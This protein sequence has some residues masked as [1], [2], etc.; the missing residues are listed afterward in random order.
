MHKYLIIGLSVLL[1]GGC[2][3][4]MPP[5]ERVD[6][7]VVEGVNFIGM[8]VSD[9]DATTSLYQDATNVQVVMDDRIENDLVFNELVGRDGAAVSTRLLTGVNAQLL[10]M[11]FDNPSTQ[12]INTRSIDSN[13]PGIAH[14]AFQVILKTQT[15]QKFLEGG[16]THI[17]SL[18][19]MK[20]PKSQVSYAYIRDKDNIIVEIEHVDIDALDLPAPPKNDR[21]I[22]HISLAT[23]DMDRAVTFYE[24]LLQTENP[25]RYGHFFHNE[26]EFIDNVSGLPESETEMAWFQVRNLELEL[27]QYH[28]PVPPTLEVKP[29]DATGFNMIVFDVTNIQAAR[30]IFVQAGGKVVLEPSTVFGG[31]AFF[32]RDPDGNLLGFQA[33]DPKSPFSAKKFKDNGLG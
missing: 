16:A 29:L 19:M 7:P 11:Q 20:N 31:E 13:G 18:E 12:A 24:T 2:S 17:G 9:L 32:G 28:N 21:R 15:Y 5:P 1:I 26:S 22:R 27:I 10:L 8:T 3:W 6:N 30:D 33:L 4:L 23:S 14:L 25:R